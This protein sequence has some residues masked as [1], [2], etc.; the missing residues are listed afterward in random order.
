MFLNTL[1]GTLIHLAT[2]TLT[3]TD[4]KNGLTASVVIG[5]AG[6]KY[7]KD[8]FNGEIKCGEQVVSKIFGSYMGYI[9]FDGLRYWDERR[10]TTYEIV[11]T[12][13]S[14]ALPS[15]WRN[16]LDT[17]LH[18]EGNME[19]AQENKDKLEND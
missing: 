16:R 17:I 8:Y 10:S 11:G 19:A 12:E 7:P 3:F 2:G 1:V 6:K 18:Q 5:G 9:E 13:L 4:E 15:D 14:E